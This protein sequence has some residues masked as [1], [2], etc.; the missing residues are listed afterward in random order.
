VTLSY[1]KEDAAGVVDEYTGRADATSANPGLIGN[2]PKE[3]HD[4][5]KPH[6]TGTK[7]YDD[8]LVS[9][10]SLRKGNL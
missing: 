2:E 8:I 3:S 6:G 10:A 1:L 4:G 5:D 7:G 9:T